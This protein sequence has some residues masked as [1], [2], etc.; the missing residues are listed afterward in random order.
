MF[1]LGIE[2]SCDETAAAVLQDDKVLSNIVS[3]QIQIHQKYGGVVPELASRAHIENLLPVIREALHEASVGIDDI[4]LV[5][6]TYA[7]GLIGALLVGVSAA[8]AIAYARD[9]PFVGVHHG[10][11]HILAAH[12]EYPDIGYP[13]IAL[14]ASGGHTALYHVRDFGKYELLGQTRDDAA[15]EAFDKVA[16]LL[17][18][19]YPGG[20]IIDRLAKGGNPDAITFPRAKREGYDFSFSGLKTAVRNHVALFTSKDAGI[21][22]ELKIKDVAASF[23]AAVVE[24]LVEKTIKAALEHDVH[25]IVVAGGVAANSSL[26]NIMKEKADEKGIKLYLPGMGLCIDNAAMIGLAG[27]LHY[28][29]GETSGLDLNPRASMAL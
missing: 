22:P 24:V 26:R 4:G 10:E 5:A 7:P 27:Y 20:P 1:T 3:S 18:L 21:E 14:L 16:K 6:V 8:K 11:G 2:T 12:I 19:E 29:R 13:Y 25:K 9:I 23:Q 15:G 28:Q 17:Q